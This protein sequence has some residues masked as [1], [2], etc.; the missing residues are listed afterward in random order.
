MQK[1]LYRSRK[2]RII[3]GV[4]GGLAE[5]FGHDVVLWRIGLIVLF[6]LTGFMPLALIYLIAWVVIPEA[7]EFEY[8]VRE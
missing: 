4:C 5:Y 2:Q 8:V 7:P 1:R 6:V 3:A